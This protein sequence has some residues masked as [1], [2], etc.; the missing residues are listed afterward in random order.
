MFSFLFILFGAVLGRIDGGGIVKIN[1][2]V[3][4]I[5]IMTCFAFACSFD[6]GF[7]SIIAYLGMF[8]IAT[9]HGQ[10]FPSVEVKAQ[11]PEFFDFIVS[12]F[13]GNDPRASLKYKSFRNSPIEQQ[14][15]E[16]LKLDIDQY[17]SKKLYW[18][19][20]FGMFITGSIVGIPSAVL[21]LIFGNVYGALFLLTG[22]VK[23]ISYLF[24]WQYFRNT[25]PAEYMNGAGRNVLCLIVLIFAARGI[26][27]MIF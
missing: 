12:R 14:P 17:G 3:E 1:E 10:Y 23:S 5:L 18:R 7:W 26:S 19:N 13:F 24:A 11:K 8:G 2:W 6:A 27:C 21:L 15:K 22:V 20:A 25:V 9:G 16:L 4:R